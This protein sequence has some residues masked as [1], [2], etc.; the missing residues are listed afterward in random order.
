MTSTNEL[1]EAIGAATAATSANIIQKVIDTNILE[2]QRRFSPLLAAVPTKKWNTN[3]YFFVQRNKRPSGGA[4]VDGGARASSNSV[5]A[6]NSFTI[7]NYLLQTGVTGFAQAVTA[8]VVGDLVRQELDGG[9]QSQLWAL[10]TS[11]LYGNAAATLGLSAIPGPGPDMDGLD[12]LVSTYSGS[13]Q[14]VINA[15]G[16]ALA[17]NSTS[18][19]GSGTAGYNID[20]LIDLVEENSASAIGGQYMF[21][22]SP[23]TVNRLGGLML[24]EQRF[25]GTTSV[26]AGLTVQTYRD[27]PLIKSSFLAARGTTFGTV[28]PSAGGTGGTLAAGTYYYQV[29]AVIN[30]FG[31]VQ[32]STEVS[33]AVTSGQNVTLTFA[34]PADGE[35]NEPILYKVYRGSTAGSE[36][37]VGVVASADDQGNAVTS[38][39]DNGTTLL[40]NGR[41]QTAQAPWPTSYAGAPGALGVQKP[42]ATG[43]E[44]LYLVPRNADYMVRPFVRDFQTLA[45]AQTSSAPDVLPFAILND[46]CL[47][48]RA[49][50]YV[51]K[52][53]NFTVT[54]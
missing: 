30:R 54:L 39:V 4:A 23:R 8:G 22:G 43:T 28:A 52:L 9:M 11:M 46:T 21:I 49:P 35:G 32:A 29:S 13:Q 12:T 48:V 33:Q 19:G 47:A 17:L 5:W 41:S 7:K 42:R 2:Y 37:L 26:A 31:E 16:K 40:V 51:A 25:V 44:C 18:Q 38:I 45:L 1:Q 27:I 15:T 34:T 50:K 10:E 3:T 24:N 53:E 20:D 14:N 6:Q 36:V